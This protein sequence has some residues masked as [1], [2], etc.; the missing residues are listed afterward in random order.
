MAAFS[1]SAYHPFDD[2]CT[3]ADYSSS[4]ADSDS[5]RTGN[6]VMKLSRCEILL[7]YLASCSEQRAASA[8]C[9]LFVDQVTH[10]YWGSAMN[11][12]AAWNAT[13]QVVRVTLQEL[14][15]VQ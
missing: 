12:G 5:C 9:S 13:A 14:A 4:N 1:T 11:E 6:C 15:P 10:P 8:V 2:E 7:S 3:L